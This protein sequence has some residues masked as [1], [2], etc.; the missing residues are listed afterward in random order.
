MPARL[1]T[2]ERF[3]SGNN[4]VV[5]GKGGHFFQSFDGPLP[6]FGER[7]ERFHFA[8]GRRDYAEHSAAKCASHRDAIFH[9]GNAVAANLFVRVQ[10]IAP[11]VSAVIPGSGQ[12]LQ[13]KARAIVYAG[14]EAL[15]W[16]KLYDDRRQQARLEREFRELARTVARSHFAASP[17]DTSE[18]AY[19]ELMRH[20]LESGAFSMNGSGPLVPEKDTL[21]FNGSLW[22]QI[23]ERHGTDV[24]G[25][26]REYSE[27]AVPADFQWSWRNAQLQF[28]IYRRT[29]D[30]RNDA[31]KSV[32]N[33]LAVLGLNHLFSMV[34]AFASYR[35]QF[36]PRAGGGF[37]V[38]F[39]LP[40]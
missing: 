20:F 13:G 11:L 36:R 28:D 9:V 21:T 29:T 30:K 6:F 33:D 2:I 38:G 25:A 19:Y 16:Y 39:S 37:D 26:L 8:Y 5:R 7:G 10:Q 40:R 34:D 23:S 17:R 22:A 3:D 14:I 1:K 18:W 31:A 12:L 35:L 24:A 15:V 27:R 4:T 32:A